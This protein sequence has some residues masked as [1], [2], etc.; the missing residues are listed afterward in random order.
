MKPTAL[1]AQPLSEAEIEEL[2]HFLGSDAVPE[3]AMDVSMLDGF[4]TAIASG[5]NLM[6]PSELLRWVWDPEARQA[7]PAFTD[8][9]ASQRIVGVILRHWND[10]NDRLSHAPEQYEPLV[11][12]R[13]SNGSMVSVIDEWC[14]GYFKGIV[15]DRAA[16]APLLAEHPDWFTVIILYGTEDGWE[17]LKRRKDSPEQH[18]AFADSLGE[19]ARRIHHYWLAQRKAQIARGEL[20]GVLSRNEPLR[21]TPKVGRNDACP[22][23]SGKKYKRCHGTGE[24]DQGLTRA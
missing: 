5:P 16:W 13:E 23:G 24:T 21:R 15:A 14:I 9:E 19:S 11:M 3:E 8:A 22:C 2:D 4:I 7:S 17:E 18:Q 20:P 1:L 6:M 10:V 12:E